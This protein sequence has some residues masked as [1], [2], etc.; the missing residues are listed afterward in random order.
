M[1]I[2]FSAVPI[3]LAT[4]AVVAGCRTSSSGGHTAS[5]TIP[6]LD[7]E[8]ARAAGFSL[9]QVHE[10]TVVYT[11]KCARCHKFYDPTG[12]T[13]AEWHSW[14]RKMSTKARLNPNQEQLLSRYLEAIRTS[15][16]AQKSGTDSEP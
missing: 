14:M 1:R 16:G 5:S 3:V 12:Y 2:R 13:D 7:A 8:S 10:A 4:A 6:A 11:A 15:G 9:Q